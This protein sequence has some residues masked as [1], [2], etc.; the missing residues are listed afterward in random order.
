MAVLSVLFILFIVIVVISRVTS[1]P[2]IAVFQNKALIVGGVSY[3][4]TQLSKALLYRD[5][6][7]LVRPGNMPSAHSALV[8]AVTMTMGLEKGLADFSFA[9]AL[10]IAAIIMVEAL[11]SRREIGELAEEINL[12]KREIILE[13]AAGH[14]SSEVIVGAVIGIIIAVII[15]CAT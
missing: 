15:W 5:W 2:I 8:V 13:E 14:K 3:V 12:L 6:Q 1:E 9:L 4:I 7:K 10:V 11:T